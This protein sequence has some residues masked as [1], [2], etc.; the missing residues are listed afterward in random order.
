M[1]AIETAKEF[2]DKVK[3]DRDALNG[4]IADSGRA[5][6]CI[7]SSY[8]LHEWVW[9]NWLKKKCPFKLRGKLI[10]DKEAFLGWLDKNCPHF[11]VLQELANGSKHCR[12]VHS[13]GKVSGYGMGPYGIGP[14][15]A[16]YLLIDLGSHLAGDERYLV[17]STTLNQIVEFWE[18]IFTE[19]DIA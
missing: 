3:Q 2:F 11:S 17:V 9:A 15:G 10:R 8:H 5:I 14:Y 7:L 16:P 12:P 19:H 1:F 13:T 4:D 6:N 18:N